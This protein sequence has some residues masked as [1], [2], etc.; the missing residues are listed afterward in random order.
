MQTINQVYGIME[1]KIQEGSPNQNISNNSQINNYSIDHPV[2]KTL[3]MD[4]QY[5]GFKKSLST[6]NTD[7]KDNSNIFNGNDQKLYF[8]MI[9]DYGQNNNKHK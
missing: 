1:K 7:Y 6:N 2:K 9:N 4:S 8:Q 3:K 5:I